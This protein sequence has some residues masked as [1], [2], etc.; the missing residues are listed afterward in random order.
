MEES[1]QTS[2]FSIVLILRETYFFRSMSSAVDCRLPTSERTAFCTG[3]QQTVS[4]DT[5]IFNRFPP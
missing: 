3:T 4:A 5:D 1:L 2:V